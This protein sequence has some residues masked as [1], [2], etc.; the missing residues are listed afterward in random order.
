MSLEDDNTSNLPEA[1]PIGS[2]QHIKKAVQNS[3]VTKA[4][5]SFKVSLNTIIKQQ[6][7][8]FSNIDDLTN[9]LHSYA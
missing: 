7:A 9:N 4:G 1:T 3:A 2:N 6:A 5:N 8:M